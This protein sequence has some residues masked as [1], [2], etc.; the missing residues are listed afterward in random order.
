M[1][2]SLSWAVKDAADT[3]LMVLEAFVMSRAED[4][5]VLDAEPAS[6][7]PFQMQSFSQ[8]YLAVKTSGFSS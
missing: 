5:S 8:R 2:N 7:S 1:D 6:A 3:Q 4:W